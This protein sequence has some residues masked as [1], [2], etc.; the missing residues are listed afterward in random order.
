MFR[1]TVMTGLAMALLAGGLAF[2]GAQ[3]RIKGTVV[4]GSGQPIADAVITI[5]CDAIDGYKKVLHT[6]SKGE[7]STVILDATRHYKFHVEAPGYIPY[8]EPFKVPAGSVDNKFTFTLKTR[9]EMAKL[10]QQKLLEQPGYKQV[11]EAKALLKKGDKAGARAKLREAVEAKP[12]LTV[13]W[14]SLA[15]MDMAAGDTKA[16]LADA[17]KCLELDDESVDCLAVAINACKALG[18]EKDAEAYMARYKELNPDDPATIFNEAAQYLNKMD[19]EHARP[20]LEKCLEVDPDY[21]E[22]IYEYGMLLLRTGDMPGA[23]KELQH[24]LEVAPNGPQAGGVKE[25]LKYL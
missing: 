18:K 1:K 24:Y 16:A 2:A 22:C 12:D 9:E 19:D 25:T 8:E 15:N 5:T 11:E 13:A 3:A 21:P 23:K 6:N 7:F 10:E 4:N 17:K 20:L 14:E